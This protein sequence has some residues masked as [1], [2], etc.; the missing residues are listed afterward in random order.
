MNLRSKG[1]FKR[2]FISIAELKSIRS[3]Q[4]KCQRLIVNHIGI[5]GM[6]NNRGLEIIG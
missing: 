6:K 3:G 2:K 5:T 1:E 4:G